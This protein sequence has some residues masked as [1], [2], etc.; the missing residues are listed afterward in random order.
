[1]I[2]LFCWIALTVALPAQAPETPVRTGARLQSMIDRSTA[3]MRPE[4]LIPP[5]VYR[6]A[7]PPN[8]PVHLTIRNYDVG[9]TQLTFR[10]VESSIMMVHPQSEEVD[11]LHS[12]KQSVG[13][14][15]PRWIVWL[16]FLSTGP[17]IL[18]WWMLL[19]RYL[20]TRAGGVLA[21][22]FSPVGKT[23]ASVN[24]QFPSARLLLWDVQKGTVR[25]IMYS[26]WNQFV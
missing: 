6:I 20:D 17:F 19:P 22:A 3:Q 25:R 2:R 8:S 10:L 7:P 13:R 1:M 5:G 18:R 16:V 9:Q 15:H 24:G 12:I 21:L 26:S 14:R 4:L 23:L 11:M